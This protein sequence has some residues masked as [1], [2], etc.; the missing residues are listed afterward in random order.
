MYD[1]NQQAFG[2]FGAPDVLPQSYGA[3][4]AQKI[5][6][7]AQQ[8]QPQ[9]SEQH[10]WETMFFQ[11]SSPAPANLSLFS[12]DNKPLPYI[13]GGATDGQVQTATGIIGLI[14][15]IQARMKVSKTGTISDDQI[16][17]YQRAKEITVDG[18]I[19]PET[20]AKLGLLGPYVGG[21]SSS[22]S[23]SRSSS[24]ASPPPPIGKEPFYKN[25]YFIYGMS[26]VL[27]L[28]AGYFIYSMQKK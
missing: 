17:E 11:T 28:G 14:T 18:I 8:A 23:P 2:H 6:D 7:M 1:Q 13:K 12:R 20:Y 26:G 25:K 19:G 22:S 21:S 16:K 10:A 9:Q 27:L 15:E 4:T 24:V 3:G 5:L